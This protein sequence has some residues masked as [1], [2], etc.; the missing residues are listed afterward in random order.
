MTEIHITNKVELEHD[1]SAAIST[2][3]CCR[4]CGQGS[5]RCSNRLQLLAVSGRQDQLGAAPAVSC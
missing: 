5:A 3:A 2:D 1:C 4:V